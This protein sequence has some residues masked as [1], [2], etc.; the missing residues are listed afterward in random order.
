MDKFYKIVS[1]GVVL[2]LTI[3]P[4]I[5]LLQ[6]EAPT[7][8]KIDIGIID[9]RLAASSWMVS[10]LVGFLA[11]I[12]L[13]LTIIFENRV[14]KNVRGISEYYFPYALSFGDIQ[15]NLQN[16]INATRKKD[17]ISLFYAYFIS[18]F[19]L[20]SLWVFVIL[21]YF[22]PKQIAWKE[23]LSID[24]NILDASGLI[25]YGLGLS[26]WLITLLFGVVLCCVI[27]DVNIISKIKLP[28]NNQITSI[29]YLKAVG[30]D[31][32][33]IIYK[34]SPQLS[35]Y[36]I[37]NQHINYEV[38]L[39]S[40]LSLHDLTY[41]YKFYDQTAKVNMYYKIKKNTSAE[42]SI[43]K[44]DLIK[45]EVEAQYGKEIIEKIFT[46]K[47]TCE[48]QIYDN[49]G[50]CVGRYLCKNNLNNENIHV[51]C[52]DRR[53]PIGDNLEMEKIKSLK[54]GISIEHNL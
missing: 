15:R 27:N 20:N 50:N 29:T 31:V 2:L 5:F 10:G 45:L 49:E 16:Y 26:F 30:A 33:E 36:Q 39:D 8:S 41:A 43:L 40:S 3:L 52:I 19:S 14:F 44:N 35:V 22:P 24:F 13:Y 53:I 23:L 25:L 1:W 37:E 11:F 42:K 46:E 51:F 7:L 34:I 47:L 17:L 6:T 38:Y 4:F 28:Q 48:L 9:K 12:V 32:S 54:A 21:Y 18:V